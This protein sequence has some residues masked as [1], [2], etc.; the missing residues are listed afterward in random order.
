MADSQ[1]SHHKPDLRWDTITPTIITTVLATAVVILRLIVRCKFVKAVGFDD[2]V[3]VVSLFLS[4]VVLGLTVAMVVTDFGSYAW[5]SPLDLH[6]ATAKLFLSWNVLYVVLIHV[7]KASILTQYLRIF[8]ARTMQRLT[9]LLF[10]ALVPSPLWGVFGSIFIC[11]PV[12]K[13]W[14]PIEPVEP[15]EHDIEK[16][17]VDQT[18][19]TT[20]RSASSADRLEKITEELEDFDELTLVGTR[21]GIMNTE[22]RNHRTKSWSEQTILDMEGAIARP[23]VAV[24]SPLTAHM[25]E[26]DREL[27]EEQG[28]VLDVLEGR[29][30]IKA[31]I[32]VAIMMF[33]VANEDESARGAEAQALR[34][35]QHDD[36]NP[37]TNC[38]LECGGGRKLT[39]R[40]QQQRQV[41]KSQAQPHTAPSTMLLPRIRALPTGSSSAITTVETALSALRLSPAVTNTSIAVR[42]ASHK[43]QGAANSAKDG[44]GKRLGAKKSGEQYVIPGNIIFRQR[45]TKWFPGDNVGMGRDHTIYATQPGYVKYYKDPLK[46]PK[47]QYIGV[48]FER[49]QVLPQPPHAV[50][51]RRLGMLAHQMENSSPSAVEFTGDFSPSNE[52]AIPG[53]ANISTSTPPAASK[54]QKAK[55]VV[56]DKRTGEVVRA[57]PTLR[58]GYQYR[59]ANWEIGRAAERAGVKV[60]PFKPGNRFLA[61]RKSNVRKAKNAERRGLTRR[62]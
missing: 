16:A 48:V 22:M 37:I 21:E 51:R 13:I 5:H 52:A 1:S 25:L 58:P 53:E 4:W 8:P 3:I 59:A 35:F 42:H 32:H 12:R 55:V 54:E 61:W 56:K 33:V 7:T 9:W 50:R 6:S 19:G 18:D 62:R 34:K 29:D 46:H 41:D 15:P 14:H 17:E 27:R 26:E 60:T 40:E 49:N 31:T 44:A 30:S 10:A 24:A 57:T 38:G 28:S 47:R 36:Q 2:F 20:S 11:D 39:N 43:A 45:G 23:E